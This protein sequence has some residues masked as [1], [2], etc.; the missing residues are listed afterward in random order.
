[1]PKSPAHKHQIIAHHIIGSAN[2][3]THFDHVVFCEKNILRFDVTV[4]DLPSVDV[5]QCQAHLNEP[6]HDLL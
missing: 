4:D 1:M 2:Q 6:L 5:L 3:H